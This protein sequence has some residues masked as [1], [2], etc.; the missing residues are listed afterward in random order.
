MQLSDHD[1]RQL[2]EAYLESLSEGQ[3]RALLSKA[4]ADL[5]AAHERLGQNPSN[6][7]RSPSTRAP[8]EQAGEDEQKTGR[9][10]PSPPRG[11]GE[12]DAAPEASSEEEAP[13]RQG[14]GKSREASSRPGKPG[15][16]KGAPGHSHT[17]QLPIDAEVSHAPDC[18][19]G[20]ERM[21]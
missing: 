8:W 12:T 19:T 13:A 5:K 16:R 6:S 21:P 2:D 17:L 4:F 7:S 14:R 15:R 20:V 11:T 1:L 9:E 10:A 18:C 3:A